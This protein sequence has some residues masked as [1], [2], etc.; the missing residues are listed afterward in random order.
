MPCSC[1]QGLVLV[2]SACFCNWN[3]TLC[4][5]FVLLHVLD[6]FAV[7][8]GVT[9]VASR[10][11]RRNF[12]RGL[13]TYGSK[14]HRRLGYKRMPGRMGGTNTD[15]ESST[16]ITTSPVEAQ[17]RGSAVPPTK[18]VD[19]GKNI[20]RNR[21]FFQTLL[22]SGCNSLLITI[23]LYTRNFRPVEKLIFRYE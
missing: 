14:S 2:S 21:F 22:H 10:F 9:Q 12:K 20:R 18:I 19:N 23:F 4:E 5:A 16:S 8:G 7:T 13:V 6:R 3:A 11:K 17:G 1:C 15:Q